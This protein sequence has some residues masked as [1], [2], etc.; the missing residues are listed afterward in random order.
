M[1]SPEEIKKDYQMFIDIQMSKFFK[2]TGQSAFKNDKEANDVLKIIIGVYNNQI[3]TDHLR[4]DNLADEA[5]AT[6]FNSVEINFNNINLNNV[7]SNNLESNY[8]LN[9]IDIG[10][11]EH[12]EEM[13]ETLKEFDE[14]FDFLPKGAMPVILNGLPLFEI[15][16]YPIERFRNIVSGEIKTR[17]FDEEIFSWVFDT[18]LAIMD[19]VLNKNK[20]ERQLAYQ[21]AIEIAQD[22]LD[23]DEAKFVVE[24]IKMSYENVVL[25][26]RRN[27]KTNKKRKSKKRRKK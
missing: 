4:L 16:G 17:K 13:Y 22:F 23:D 2:L 7:K 5:K 3:A 11:D 8:A 6:W 25:K 24:E 26:S 14:I 9:D 10:D 21:E 1:K 15:Y 18:S 19:S 20:D 27:S 12:L